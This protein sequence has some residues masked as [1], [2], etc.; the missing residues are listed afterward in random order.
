LLALRNPKAFPALLAHHPRAFDP[1]AAAQLPISLSGHTHGAQ[2]MLNAV[3]TVKTATARNDSTGSVY[4]SR[5]EGSRR[6]RGGSRRRFHRDDDLLVAENSE[7]SD[8]R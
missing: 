5:A 6:P 4:R 1:A 3:N 7:P 2:L 8:I